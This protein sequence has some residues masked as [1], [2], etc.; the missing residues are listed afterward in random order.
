MNQTE[1][2]QPCELRLERPR[3]QAGRPLEA[4]EMSRLIRPDRK[5]DQQPRQRPG[6]EDRGEWIIALGLAYCG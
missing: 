2:L 4:A 6:G 3:G 5:V 1:L